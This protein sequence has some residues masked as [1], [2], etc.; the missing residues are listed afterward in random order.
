MTNCY[1]DLPSRSTTWVGL[2]WMKAGAAQ[3]IKHFSTGARSKSKAGKKSYAA[4][5]KLDL[6]NNPQR[7]I[8]T[9]AA[10]A[11]SG[12]LIVRVTNIRQPYRFAISWWTFRSGINRAESAS[13]GERFGEIWRQKRPRQSVPVS[14]RPACRPQMRGWSTPELAQP[15]LNHHEHL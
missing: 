2:R 13:S 12:E 11:N 14:G 10:K 8:R 1:R 9:R 15:H 4:L 6:G 7:Y 5:L 3:A